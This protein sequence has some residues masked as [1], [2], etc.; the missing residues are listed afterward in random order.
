MK[1]S[2]FTHYYVHKLLKE[3]I[4]SSNCL[5]VEG[6]S[7]QPSHQL[8]LHQA[9]GRLYPNPADQASKVKELEFLTTFCQ[10]IEKDKYQQESLRQIKQQ[11]FQLLGFNLIAV[12][13]EQL[14]TILPEEEAHWFRVYQNCCVQECLRY[15]HE[16]YGLAHDFKNADR[17]QAYQF[18]WA[19]AKQG[20]PLLLTVSTSRYVIW[21]KL[22]SPA[23]A[24]LPKQ[25]KWLLKMVLPLYSTLS[26]FKQVAVYSL[27]QPMV[28]T[29]P[30]PEMLETRRTA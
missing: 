28:M 26:K 9:L 6:I 4:D 1:L 23:Y 24:R 5:R 12:L 21:V 10:A 15:K 22:R 11:I 17:L 27:L 16:Y 7:S 14:P 30:I 13:P 19:L 29:A 20:I 18:A 8:D 25:S 2:P 3:Y